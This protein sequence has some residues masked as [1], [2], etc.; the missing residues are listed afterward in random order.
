VRRFCVGLAVL[1]GGG[2]MASGCSSPAGSGSASATAR[3]SATAAASATATAG[4]GATNPAST[5]KNTTETIQVGPMSEFFDS[6]LPADPAQAAVVEGFRTAMIAWDQSERSAKLTPSVTT[7]VTGPALVN[8]K[9]AIKWLNSNAVTPGGADRLF[10][11][12]VTALSA[13]GATVTSC[14]DGSK[15]VDL[16]KST[17]LPDQELT[18]PADQQYLL[19][20]V[21]MTRQDNRWG[22]SRLTVSMLPN[23]L[24]KP[25]QPKTAH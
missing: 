12:R 3:T 4:A 23:A 18:A 24:A 9:A 2:L 19:L 11:T 16:N 7:V 10:D 17:G 1:V 14:D 20:T 25:C 5:G 21:Q 13:S 6:P 8:L 22:I 15:F